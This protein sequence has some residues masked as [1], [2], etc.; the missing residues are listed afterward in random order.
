[1]KKPTKQQI[2]EAIREIALYYGFDVCMEKRIP[3]EEIRPS[4]VLLLSYRFGSMSE[5]VK[6]G[7]FKYGQ[8][9]YVVYGWCN[10]KLVCFMS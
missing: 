2:R 10:G 7:H 9:G 6:M 1:M 5:E 3:G 4:G 8:K